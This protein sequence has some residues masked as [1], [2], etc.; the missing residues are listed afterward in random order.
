MS[1]S[2]LNFRGS[3]SQRHMNRITS[4]MLRFVCGH[5]SAGWVRI[6]SE[7]VAVGWRMF[8]SIRQ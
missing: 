8:V 1:R 7:K 3:S 2:R 5:P 6:G 4:A